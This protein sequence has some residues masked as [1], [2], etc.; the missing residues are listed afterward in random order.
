MDSTISCE[1]LK[2]IG[3]YH[4]PENINFSP[5][6]APSKRLLNIIPKYNKP[7]YGN[8]IALQVGLSAMMEK[9]PRFR[10]WINKIVAKLKD[11]EFC[12]GDQQ[13]TLANHSGGEV[14]LRGLPWSP[15]DFWLPVEADKNRSS[16]ITSTYK[17]QPFP[18]ELQ[19]P[20]VAQDT[21]QDAC[22]VFRTCP[23]L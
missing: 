17:P 7:L 9:C 5:N 20:R 23:D 22:P 1:T 12:P 8:I 4:N 11:Q 3:Q 10:E 2:I 21:S 18:S 15:S 6:S 14:P 13:S 16:P 19:G